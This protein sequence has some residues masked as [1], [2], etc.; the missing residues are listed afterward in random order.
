M[1]ERRGLMDIIKKREE[2]IKKY[3]ETQIQ[4]YRLDGAIWMCEAILNDAGEEP[5]KEGDA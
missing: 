1:S 3:D 5:Q 2:L 4:L